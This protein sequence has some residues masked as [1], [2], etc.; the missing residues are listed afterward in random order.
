[1][2]E[3]NATVNL[4]KEDLRDLVVSAVSAAVS[5]ANAPP[6]PTKAEL[7]EIQ[8]A[9]ELRESTA[10]DIL[11]KKA[12]DRWFQEHG[13]SHEHSKQAGGGTHCVHV[14]DNDYLDSAGYIMCQ[15]C[16]GRVR[17]EDPK[18]VKLDPEAIF[19]TALFNKLFQDCAQIQ[20][21]ML[22]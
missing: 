17:P 9:Q 1:M 14:R 21:E 18:W 15:L 6:P 19:N 4:T 11:K 10:K 13:C 7:A 3:G 2:N 20:G 16:Q 12:N 5:A 8:M 22:G